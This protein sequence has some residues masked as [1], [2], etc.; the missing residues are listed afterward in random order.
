MGNV[1]TLSVNSIHSDDGDLDLDPNFRHSDPS[2][3][4]PSWF[5]LGHFHLNRR[6]RQ[7]VD[8][9][10]TIESWRFGG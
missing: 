7:R 8:L 9:T 4:L 2:L 1:L 6:Y 10:V 3:L 5:H